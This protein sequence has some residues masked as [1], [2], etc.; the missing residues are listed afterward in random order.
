MPV[1]APLTHDGEGN[2]L[3]TNADTIGSALA[4]ELSKSFTVNLIYA[5]EMNGVMGNIDDSNSL[6]RNLEYDD[7]MDLKKGI[8]GEYI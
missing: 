6:I 2:M 8:F 3:N 1:I 7:Y 5:F 4:I